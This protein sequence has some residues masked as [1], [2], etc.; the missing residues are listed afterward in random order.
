MEQSLKSYGLKIYALLLLFYVAPT[1]ARENS[2]PSGTATG[3]YNSRDVGLEDN[4]DTGRSEPVY[5][6]EHLERLRRAVSPRYVRVMDWSHYR[7]SGQMLLRGILFT[8]EGYRA[9]KVFIAG[10]FSNW[11]LIPMRR[12][13]RGVYYHVLPVREIEAGNRLKDYSYKFLV[14]GI[15]NHDP[16]HPNTRDDG[17]GGYVSRFHLEKEDVPRQI[18]VRILKEVRTGADRLVEFAIYLPNIEN[19]ALVGNFNAWNPE[20]DLPV[21]GPDGI[22]RLRLRLKPGEYVY[23]YVADGRWMVDPF[24]P[25]TRFDPQIGELCSFLS[26]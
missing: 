24:N 20:H 7:A 17:L 4:F 26:I 3:S 5:N 25:D 8:Y 12:N 15:W 22:F 14:D 23:K 19:L 11:K 9:Q 1:L 10:D 13:Q 18:S 16:S 2:L 21:K 6:L